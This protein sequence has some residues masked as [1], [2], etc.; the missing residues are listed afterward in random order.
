MGR[1]AFVTDSTAGVPQEQVEQYGVTVVP[2]QVIFGTET[3]RDGI[4]LTQQQFFTRLKAA[5]T[6]PTTSQ[7]SVGDF[8]NAFSKLASDPDVDSIVC[9]SLSSGLSGTVNAARQAAETVTASSNKR[10]SVIDSLSVYMCEGFMVIN[11]A[12]AAQAG[13]SHDEVVALIERIVP[14]IK[15]LVL[16]DTLEYLAKGGRIGGAQAFLGGLLNV[17]PILHVEGGRVEPLERVRTRRKAME[18]LIDLGIEATKGQPVQI[19]V[20]H[21]QAE[22]D[23]RAL[24]EMVKTRMNVTELFFGE[25]GPVIST[26]TGPGA[27]GFV[28][29]PAE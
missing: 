14:R 18:R 2:L 20:G 6:L 8:Q 12:R 26:H 1:I 24:G 28:Y 17:K 25:I 23:A 13:K 19:C 7:P 3:F 9:V 29:N 4:D 15:L 16:V 5:K 22:E 11:G 27:I 10:I 21:A